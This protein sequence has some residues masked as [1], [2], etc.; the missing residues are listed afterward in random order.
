MSKSTYCYSITWNICIYGHQ[1]KV[2]ALTTY[3]ENGFQRNLKTGAVF[4][5]HAKNGNNSFTPVDIT[6][7]CCKSVITIISV[8]AIFDVSLHR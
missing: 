1:S 6:A 4:L 7:I 8:F 2:T 5:S 3:I